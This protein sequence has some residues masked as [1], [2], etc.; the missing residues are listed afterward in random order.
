MVAG[1]AAHA[2]H[3]AEGA[4]NDGRTTGGRMAATTVMAIASLDDQII[5]VV[6]MSMMIA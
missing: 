2:A 5:R 1:G 6:M 4:V 3:L